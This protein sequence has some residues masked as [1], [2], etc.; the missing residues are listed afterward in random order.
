MQAK[1]IT[2]VALAAIATVL[3][4]TSPALAKHHHSR[5]HHR[6][7][8]Q[9]HRAVSASQR[10][11]TCTM[12]G[13]N[14]HRIDP[15]QRTA[16]RVVRETRR[17]GRRFVSDLRHVVESIPSTCDYGIVRRLWCGCGTARRLGLSNRDG[18]LNLASNYG[19]YFAQSAGPCL[20]CVAWRSGHAMAIIG[21][22]PGA[23][24]VYDP[25]AGPRDHRGIRQAVE[26]TISHFRGYR[27]ADPSR[28]R[29]RRLAAL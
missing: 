6:H 3:L 29:R 13:C 7:V 16:S 26:Y 14:D 20:H 4:A 1:A 5:H 27:F 22:R 18:H 21:G 25:N 12:Q 15:V 10:L 17:A 19:R 23:W 9:H 24:H 11:V 2:N 8:A 28:P